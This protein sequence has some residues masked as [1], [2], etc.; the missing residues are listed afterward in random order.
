MAVRLAEFK[1]TFLAADSLE[2]T[3]NQR[4]PDTPTF[5]VKVAT[6]IASCVPISGNG[7]SE[8]VL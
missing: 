2:I 5:F 6:F 8:I 3:L 7:C 1:T 4:G